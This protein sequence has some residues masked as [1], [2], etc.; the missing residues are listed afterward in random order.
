M[1][2]FTY[3]S[4]NEPRIPLRCKIKR[5]FIFKPANKHCEWGLEYPHEL[6]L[7]FVCPNFIR[8]GF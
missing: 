7:C 4:I 6:S 8:E 3:I 2:K 5:Q 1:D